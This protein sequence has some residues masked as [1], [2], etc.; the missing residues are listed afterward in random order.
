MGSNFWRL[1]NLKVWQSFFF[2]IQIFVFNRKRLAKFQRGIS[3][4][5]H[6]FH[7]FACV[8]D[9]QFFVDAIRLLA[10]SRTPVAIIFCFVIVQV[11]FSEEKSSWENEECV[12]Q[13]ENPKA[14][15]GWNRDSEESLVRYFVD[16]TKSLWNY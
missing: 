6:Q 4:N 10:E 7:L 15:Q 5:G 13:T 16:E 14:D 1:V 12:G 11:G 2:R 3:T 8:N 9:L